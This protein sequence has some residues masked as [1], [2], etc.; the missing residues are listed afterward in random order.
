MPGKTREQ[1]KNTPEAVKKRNQRAANREAEI[2]KN[3]LS[4]I[5]ESVFQ[6]SEG[7]LLD[8][9]AY[10]LRMSRNIGVVAMKDAPVRQFFIDIQESFGTDSILHLPAD[11]TIQGT[12]P[13]MEMDQLEITEDLVKVNGKVLVVSDLLIF[14]GV[15]FSQDPERKAPKTA[16]QLSELQ[17]RRDISQPMMLFVGDGTVDDLPLTTGYSSTNRF[18]FI[19]NLPITYGLGQEGELATMMDPSIGVEH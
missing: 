6:S 17:K 1:L 14:S 4:K 16:R 19:K 12:P 11:G 8:G 15:T 5:A 18:P 10:N 3:G 2:A 7:R 9:L 13:E